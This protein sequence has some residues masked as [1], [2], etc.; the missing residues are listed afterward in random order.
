MSGNL[1]APISAPD[2][3]LLSLRAGT[4][5]SKSGKLNEL[6]SAKGQTDSTDPPNDGQRH[7]ICL[8]ASG[9]Y[10]AAYE[11]CDHKQEAKISKA[12]TRLREKQ[13]N[14]LAGCSGL[15]VVIFM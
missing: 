9:C 8:V 4:G 6:I 1:S 12:S 5:G 13:E 15:T 7:L 11:L 14:T 10:H 2:C 3:K